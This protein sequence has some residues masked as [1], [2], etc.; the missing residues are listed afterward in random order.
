MAS[1]SSQRIPGREVTVMG[2]ET[3][4]GILGAEP[5]DVVAACL[6]AETEQGR[7]PGVRWDYSGEYPL[8]DA[9]GF[10]VDR[11]AVDPS[12]LTDVPGAASVEGP[13]PGRLRTTV[14]ARLTAQEEAWQRGTAT[15]LSSGGRLYVDHGHPEY[16]T[17]ECTGA[18]QATLAD[19]AGDLL[20]ARGAELL[21]R[22]GSAAR[23]FKN[24]V[25]GKGATYGTHENYLVP[26]AI[27]FDDLTQAL[28]P[29]LVVRPL[30]LGSGRVGIG[31][32]AQNADFQISQR[33]DYLEKVVGLGTTVDRPLV[34]TRDEP[35]ADPERWRRLHLVAGDANC[36]DTMTWLK[37]GMT[38][39]VLQV[40]ADGV[41][42]SW[43][44]LRLADPVAQ[45]RDVSRDIRLRG[46]LELA[47]GRRLSAL[48]ILEHYL[49]TVRSHLESQG[50]LAPAPAGDPLRPNLAALA[51]GADTDGAETGAILAFWQASLRELETLRA[52]GDE[53][54]GPGDS[55]GPA[56]HLEWVAKKQL[57]EA[58][59]R[60]HPG[61]GGHDVLHAVDLA[62]S[63][64]SLAGRGLSERV[65]AG[66]DAR[67][68]LG[69]QM[70]EA[71][72]SEPP[73]TTRAWLRG[74]L[75][76][77]FPGQV[78]AAGWHSM[79]LETGEKDQRRL[80]LTDP[81]SFTRAIASPAVE[82]TIDVVEVLTR[83]TG[84]DLGRPAP[85]T[86]AVTVPA[87]PSGEQT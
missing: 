86:E 14:V 59:A 84:E 51:D 49:E 48:E 79:V 31:V 74:R 46:A 73:T 65:P 42:D 17:P 19:R 22:R 78:V 55:E 16:A 24:N 20:V 25:D 87:T 68:G 61:A 18:A 85:T 5:E 36:F 44:S 47:D 3:E 83:L 70:V 10:E 60:R 6:E 57:L 71:V 13:V 32:V 81:L 21:R 50:R 72:L 75:V 40:L 35:H 38:S 2:L 4:Y 43:R 27:D 66:V 62:W 9:R 26:R 29:L 41:P 37:L 56:G 28:V 58:T 82:G 53:T 39:L 52:G 8:R 12:M 33:A 11:S 7:C 34:N 15:C 23:L 30:L 63:E 45:A 64:L 54:G 80:P 76:G 77:A 67:G 1:T 69:E